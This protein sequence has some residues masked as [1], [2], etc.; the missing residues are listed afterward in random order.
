MHPH[1]L[2]YL[3]CA[4]D[5]MITALLLQMKSGWEERGWLIYVSD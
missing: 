5:I 4:K 1:P 3:I 2:D